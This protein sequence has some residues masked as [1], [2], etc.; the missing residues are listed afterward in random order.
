[1]HQHAL[2]RGSCY[3]SD[4]SG[5]G[6]RGRSA[7]AVGNGRAVNQ[8]CSSAAPGSSRLVGSSVHSRRTR[9]IALPSH[10]GITLLHGWAGAGVQS[11]QPGS[12]AAAGQLPSSSGVP[13]M[14]NIEASCFCMSIASDS[15]GPLGNSGSLRSICAMMAPAAQ[16]STAGPNLCEPSS[17]SG[18]RYH[19]VT[20]EGFALECTSP[21]TA[22]KPISA[23][24]KPTPFTSKQFSG[25]K[26]VEQSSGAWVHRCTKHPKQYS[27]ATSPPFTYLC[28][29]SSVRAWQIGQ[30]AA[31]MPKLLHLPSGTRLSQSY[32]SAHS[33]L[34]PAPHAA[35]Q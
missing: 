32:P 18:A 12:L 28:A 23:I 15:P 26:S 13:V 14:R 5:C 22:D 27:C 3:V 16:A 33:P 6:S 31:A 1:M 19:K 20:T 4:F 34:S 11:H 25:F 29:M 2:R 30:L 17:S 9:S 35:S 21:Q 24:F 7:G 8:G 10:P